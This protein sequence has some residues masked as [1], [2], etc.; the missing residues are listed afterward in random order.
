MNNFENT[1]G[2]ESGGR[3]EGEGTS[4]KKMGNSVIPWP[5]RAPKGP[6]ESNW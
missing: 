4:R 5:T 3:G 2:K 1:V 6:F